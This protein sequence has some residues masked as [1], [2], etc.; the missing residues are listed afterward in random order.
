[1]NYKTLYYNIV[2]NAQRKNRPK[3]LDIESHHIEPT[4]LGGSD[5][6]ENKVNLTL[7]E[8][9]ICHHLLTKFTSGADQKKMLFAFSWMVHTRDQYITARVYENLK[10]DVK[11]LM[12]E[13]HTGKTLSEEHKQAI[14]A[15]NKGKIVSEETRWKRSIA[16][17]GRVVSKETR[18]KLSEI[19]MGKVPSDETKALW[20][21][22]RKGTKVGKDNHMYGKKHSAKTTNQMAESR[23]NFIINRNE[24]YITPW[25]K[26]LTA[27]EAGEASGYELNHTSLRRW[28]KQ[29][30]DKPIRRQSYLQC[31]YL[32]DLGEDVVG[33]TFREIGFYYKP[34]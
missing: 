32:N 1:M 3:G 8:H 17:T 25:G 2:K 33:K 30:N 15:A 9:Y 5:T 26:F 28:C 18:D 6:S 11:L 34:F 29:N 23:R 7:K 14:S 4:A 20:S 21:K 10:R 13:V 22:Q 24:Y 12:S 27:K 31:K 19:N 16:L